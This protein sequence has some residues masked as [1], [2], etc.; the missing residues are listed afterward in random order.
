MLG[1]GSEPRLTRSQ[2][3][4]RLRDNAKCK[5]ENEKCKMKE[6][7]RCE[8]VGG[9]RI[10]VIPHTGPPTCI[11]DSA[12]L[13]SFCILHSRF[14]IFH[15]LNRRRRRWL[16]VK[17]RTQAPA[18]LAVKRRSREYLVNEANWQATSLSGGDFGD[19]I[20]F[21]PLS[22]SRRADSHPEP[23]CSSIPLARMRAWKSVF[24]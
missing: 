21:S 16:R 22:S 1:I 18:R 14:C 12:L 19:S 10:P 20:E 23:R 5:T 2:R 9:G 4:R 11:P 15:F 3:R 13:P 6:S 7:I 17:R 24:P 8:H